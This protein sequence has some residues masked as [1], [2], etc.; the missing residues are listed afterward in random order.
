MEII[1]VAAQRGSQSAHL[2]EQVAGIDEA[3]VTGRAY[4]SKLNLLSRALETA[5]Q[6]NANVVNR[7]THRGGTLTTRL[8]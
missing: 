2:A 8:C 3:T 4:W 1:Q 6:A 7:V 5:H